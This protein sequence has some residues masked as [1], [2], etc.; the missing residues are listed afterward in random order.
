MASIE[1]RTIFSKREGRD[2]VRWRLRYRD[3]GRERAEHFTKK[4][5]AEARKK[6]IEDQLHNGRLVDP[7]A[8]RQTFESFYAAWIER[9][10]RNPGT[11][12]AYDLAANSVTFGDMAM[13]DIR[14]SDLEG[15]I[16]SMQAPAEH[17]DG[18]PLAP[19]TIRT[20][21]SNVRAIFRAAVRDRVISFDPFE[22][23]EKMPKRSRGG[24]VVP[25]AEEVGN[26]MRGAPDDFRPFVALCA[27]AGLRLGEAAGLQVGDLDAL[28]R[29]LTIERQVQRENGESRFR[30]GEPKHGST[31]VVDLPAELVDMLAA[32]IAA[33]RPGDDPERWLFVGGQ[34]D[35]PP[36]QNTVGHRWRRAKAA[37]GITRR[38]RLHDLRHFYA[39]GLIAQ[40]CDLVTVQTALGHSSPA[41]TLNTYAHQWVD[42]GDRA[43]A[44]SSALFQQAADAGSDSARTQAKS[45]TR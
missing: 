8:G 18:K 24:V 7:K 42:S 21:T 28:R 15:W 41:V 33:H 25:T 17:R 35:E 45:A 13:K 2:V 36:H 6:E 22:D 38:L 30:I 39:S 27:F 31:R 10:A 14:A 12:R 9:G 26:V 40:G 11:R 29:Q 4:S 16:E 19:G 43:R 5:Y 20:R 34:D 3:G 37:A 1:K 32:Y 44:A 23:V